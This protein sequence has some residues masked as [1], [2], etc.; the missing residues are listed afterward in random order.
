MHKLILMEVLTVSLWDG[1]GAVQ[2]DAGTL[3][4]AIGYDEVLNMEGCFT[5]PSTLLLS[6]ASYQPGEAALCN[7]TCLLIVTTHYWAL[8]LLSMITEF[9]T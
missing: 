5:I 1:S 4:I 6:C 7:F 8:R 9:G 3:I 2:G